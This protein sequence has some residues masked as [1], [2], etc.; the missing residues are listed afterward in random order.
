MSLKGA[1]P[2][3]NVARDPE[4]I[5]VL[6]AECCAQKSASTIIGA[7]HVLRGHF[8]ELDA[9]GVIFD[10]TGE[11]A[12]EIEAQQTYCVSFLH[13]R[14]QCLFLTTLQRAE[15]RPFRVTFSLPT[16]VEGP[17]RRAV[18]RIP[19]VETSGLVVFMGQGEERTEAQPSDISEHGMLVSSDTD[20]PPGHVMHCQLRHQGISTDLKAMVCR[21]TERLVGLQFVEVPE[22][23]LLSQMVSALGSYWKGLQSKSWFMIFGRHQIPQCPL[24]SDARC[25]HCKGGLAG[26]RMTDNQPGFGQYVG[27]CVQCE[28]LTWYDLSS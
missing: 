25:L 14:H 19:V 18:V 2:I 28:L 3:S 23:D 24:T 12:F 9:T 17:E 20:Y 7:A 13:N 8:S 10:M 6:L 11:S 27:L 5:A 26:W 15:T 22:P 16:I 1:K 4:R 21:R